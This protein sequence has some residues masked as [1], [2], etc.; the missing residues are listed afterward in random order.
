MKKGNP[1][2]CETWKNLDGIML[3]EIS[4][5]RKDIYHLVSLVGGI[6]KKK[7]KLS[8]EKQSRLVVKKV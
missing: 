8:S 4:Q 2:F 3:S 1:T 5:I 6:L 7:K